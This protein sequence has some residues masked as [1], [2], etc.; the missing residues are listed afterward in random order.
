MPRDASPAEIERGVDESN[1]IVWEDRPVS[2]RFVSKAEAASL[3]AQEGTRSAKGTLRLIDISG[4]DLCACGGTHVDRTGAI[5]L[6]AVPRRRADARRVAADVRLRRAAP[7]ARF[8][9]YRDAVAGSVRALSVLPAELPAAIERLQDE[10]KELRKQAKGLQEKLAEREGA[11]LAAAA[12]EIEGVR[13]VVE[14]LDGWDV[15][16]L[17]SAGRRGHRI[18][19]R[20]RRARDRRAAGIRSSLPARPRCPIDANVALQQLTQP[21]RRARRRQARA[22]AGRRPRCAR[23][24]RSPRPRER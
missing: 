22:G 16:G 23:R 5:G 6:I 19:P 21:L 14:A 20:V 18:G 7:C 1:R 10:S 8:A 9:R 2:I 15:A 12:P 24:R 11:R 17:K 4:F 13:V 3:S